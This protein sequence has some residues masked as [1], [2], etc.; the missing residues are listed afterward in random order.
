MLRNEIVVV[1]LMGGQ[2]NLSSDQSYIVSVALRSN[3][4]VGLWWSSAFSSKMLVTWL[5]V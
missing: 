4:K 5:Q 3:Q 1:L 2:T